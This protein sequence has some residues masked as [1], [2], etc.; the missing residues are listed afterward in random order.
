MSSG[1]DRFG[2]M[3]PLSGWIAKTSTAVTGLVTFLVRT[4][5]HVARLF[6]HAGMRVAELES[7]QHATAAS[8]IIAGISRRSRHHV[9]AVPPECF[10]MGIYE[11]SNTGGVTSV[12]VQPSR[13]LVSLFASFISALR[14]FR[15]G[16]SSHRSQG[17]SSHPYVG[18]QC[19]AFHPLQALGTACS[20]QIERRLVSR[21]FSSVRDPLATLRFR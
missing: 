9:S 14:G 4:P 20:W 18:W 1:G 10:Q 7:S 3:R 17:L 19:L 15:L 12:I 13:L 8:P 16:G 2:A 6:C 21:G 5:S 11:D